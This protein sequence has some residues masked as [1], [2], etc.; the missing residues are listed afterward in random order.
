MKDRGG[1]AYGTKAAVKSACNTTERSRRLHCMRHNGTQWR[2]AFGTK[3]RNEERQGTAASEK[4][5]AVGQRLQQLA[6]QQE[7]GV[8][9]HQQEPAEV[10]R[11]EP[12]DKLLKQD[13]K[14]NLL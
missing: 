11:C 4:E 5:H 8:M 14:D 9:Q 6:W 10:S 1:R 12:R 7:A 2:S 13:G 3:A